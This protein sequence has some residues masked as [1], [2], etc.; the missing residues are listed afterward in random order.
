M[1]KQQ[2]NEAEVTIAQ[3]LNQ[4]SFLK[5]GS[6]PCQPRPNGSSGRVAGWVSGART[7]AE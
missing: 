7:P 1:R 2:W 3:K 4:G 6:N 5:T